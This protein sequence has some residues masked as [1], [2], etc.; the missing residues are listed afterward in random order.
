MTNLTAKE[1]KIF[2]NLSRVQS[3]SVSLG[4]KIQEIIGAIHGTPGSPVNAVA[5]QATLNVGGVV[6]HGETL[7]INNPLKVGEDNYVFMADEAQKPVVSTDIPVDIYAYTT[8][9]TI[10]LTIDT[11]PTAG[12]KMIIGTKEYTFTAIGANDAD[13]K[14]SVEVDLDGAQAA[15]VAAINGTDGVNTPNAFAKASAFDAG[16]DICAITALVGG[17]AGNAIDTIETFTAATNVFAAAKLAGGADCSAANAITAL[18]SAITASD[19]QGVGAIDGAGNTVVL[20]ADVAGVDGNDIIVDAV[21]VNGTFANAATKLAGGIN[22]TVGTAGEIH[23]DSSYVYIAIDDN[24]IT[25][26]NWRRI[27]VG[28]AYY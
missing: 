3:P 1:L 26:A 28:S 9:A 23:M 14:I 4:N 7:R 2:N 16:T 24:A 27:E 8:P 21:M 17:V 18:V 25:D 15:I 22:G 12:D 10:N 13:G 11:Q 20:T 5:A 6:I 19:T